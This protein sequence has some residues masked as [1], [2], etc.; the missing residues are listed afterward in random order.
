M[1]H[2][3]AK[4][5]CRMEGTWNLLLQGRTPPQNLVKTWKKMRHCFNCQPPRNWKNRNH[6]TKQQAVFKHCLLLC[7]KEKG[8]TLSPA[9]LKL[10]VDSTPEVDLDCSDG[11]RLD[12]DSQERTLPS[13]LA[14]EI[15]SKWEPHR[16]YKRKRSNQRIFWQFSAHYNRAG[17]ALRFSR[18]ESPNEMKS[19]SK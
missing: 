7:L 11:S 1:R 4:G 16:K 14:P 8:W 19:P 6:K 2:R 10:K 5:K 18:P 17:I 9:L 12:M 13:Y 3:I 15:G